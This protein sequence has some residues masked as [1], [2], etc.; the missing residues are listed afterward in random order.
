MGSTLVLDFGEESIDKPMS[1]EKVW[2]GKLVGLSSTRITM[3]LDRNGNNNK[4]RFRS[5]GAAPISSPRILCTFHDAPPP[6][7]SPPPSPP[8]LPMASHKVGK[9]PQAG[10]GGRVA[11]HSGAKR[12]VAGI[13]LVV[14][15]CGLLGLAVAVLRLQRGT[16]ATSDFAGQY[17]R[18]YLDTGD[19]EQL[20]SISLDDIRSID[21]AR[22]AIA[23]AA[24]ELVGSIGAPGS[25]DLYIQDDRGR[26]ARVT[27]CTS[28]Q[29][30]RDST[31]L[32]L[33]CFR[34]MDGSMD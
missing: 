3:L 7:P 32:R 21:D 27:S 23:E 9:G 22:E 5:K 29:A 11:A 26:L 24:A 34:D 25:L 31:A 30:V 20:V 18:V 10:G 13:L 6:G 4:L 28:I 12:R 8:T 1:V 17:K 33:R 19:G 16:V 2:F 14:A 15:L